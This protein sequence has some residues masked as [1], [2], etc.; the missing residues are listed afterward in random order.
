MGISIQ[1]TRTV[2]EGHL[3]YKLEGNFRPIACGN[4]V[5]SG[6]RDYFRKHSGTRRTSEGQFFRLIDREESPM[7]HASLY[8]EQ[9]IDA[10]GQVKRGAPS[11]DVKFLAMKTCDQVYHALRDQERG[12]ES[13]KEEYRRIK[14]IMSSI[15]DNEDMVLVELES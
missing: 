5:E 4:L 13:M 15:E 9:F 8:Q 10:K 6:I 14:E 12:P 1:I 11:R 7:D 3:T 2:K